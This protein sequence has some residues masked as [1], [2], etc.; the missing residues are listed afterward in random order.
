MLGVDIGFGYTKVYPGNM[1]FPS[2]ISHWRQPKMATSKPQAPDDLIIGI[3]GESYVVGRLALKQGAPGTFDKYNFDRHKVCLLAGIA[4][5]RPS[6]NGPIAVGLPISDLHNSTEP[7][8]KMAGRY[9]IDFKGASTEINIT[10]VYTYPQGA[11]IFAD[12]TLNDMGME[13]D[14][15]WS[16]KR[17]GIIDI[18]EKTANF[19]WIDRGEYI[20]SYSGSLDMGMH[21][22]Y[23]RL[24]E[25]LVRRDIV[26]PPHIVVDYLYRLDPKEIDQEYRFLANEIIDGI[27]GW[28]NYKMLDKIF[29]AGG[30]SDKLFAYM[31]ERI[32]CE[33]IGDP[34]FA[35]ARSFYK[36]AL[37][38][39]EA[40]TIIN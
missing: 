13:K 28:W 27:S 14:Q 32:N 34:R 23:T 31:K 9:K 8:K 5:K 38:D 40:E 30:G 10:E 26:V 36:S 19:C 22:A 11:T 6:Y 16:D 3:N 12:L 25:L 4:S 18:G 35:N 7:F 1:V 20:D 17:I 15:S 2:V 21:K 39:L 33:L 29:I 24:S 37:R